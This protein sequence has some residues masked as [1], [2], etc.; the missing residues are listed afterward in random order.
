VTRVLR[1]AGQGSKTAVDWLLSVLHDEL[2][3]LAQGYLDHEQPGHTLQATALVHEVY[4]KLVHQDSVGF[5]D[6][7]QFF[8]A[9]ATAMRRILV[10]HARGRKRRKRQPDGECLPLDEAVACLE[11]R[12]EDLV[13][14]DD[15][16]ARLSDFDVRKARIVEMR[17]FGGLTVEE[18]CD[19][20]NLPRRTVEREWTMA[21]AW[22]RGEVVRD[23]GRD[24]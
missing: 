13:S 10:D 14:L 7:A 20:L 4:L 18:T 22:L 19:V 9:A 17:F 3:R 24:A 12:A 5:S 15:A 11:Q 16:L 8:G 21:K 2:R 23:I 1:E 6:R